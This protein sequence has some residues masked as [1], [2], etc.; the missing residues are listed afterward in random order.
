[1]AYNSKYRLLKAGYALR[2]RSE[3]LYSKYRRN[4]TK[5][6][7]EGIQRPVFPVIEFFKA[8]DSAQLP[9]GDH[10]HR[11]DL[12]WIPTE[13]AVRLTLSCFARGWRIL[14]CAEALPAEAVS[15]SGF[16][17][18]WL[19]TQSSQYH[20]DIQYKHGDKSFFCN[21]TRCRVKLEEAPSAR[22][23][24]GALATPS[25]GGGEQMGMAGSS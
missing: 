3:C 1:M 2:K 21:P 9:C 22:D 10:R 12:M 14:R 15:S 23:T 4:S 24:F 13:I 19:I 16:F 8:I 7:T 11:G 25:F 17:Q 5:R 20:C 6:S 18:L